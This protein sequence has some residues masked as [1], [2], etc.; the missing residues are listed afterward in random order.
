MNCPGGE[1]DKQSGNRKEIII[2]LSTSFTIE[3]VLLI[4]SEYHKNKR[5]CPSVTLTLSRCYVA[6]QN[7]SMSFVN[8]FSLS[9]FDEYQ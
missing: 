6:H 8:L 4:G 2:S 5:E 1:A 7:R 3:H 9:I